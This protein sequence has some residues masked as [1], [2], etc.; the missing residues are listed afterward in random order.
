[1]TQNCDELRILFRCALRRLTFH[2][3]PTEGMRIFSAL[4]CVDSEIGLKFK[5]HNL[6]LKPETFLLLI[7]KASYCIKLSVFAINSHNSKKIF[8]ITLKNK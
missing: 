5:S 3:C 7:N 6:E 2:I 1:V 8:L 4:A